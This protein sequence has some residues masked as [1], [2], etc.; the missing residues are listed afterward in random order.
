MKTVSPFLLQ[1]CHRFQ[2]LSLKDHIQPLHEKIV[3]F[4]TFLERQAPQLFAHFFQDVGGDLDVL[5]NS[6]G[7]EVGF[8]SGVFGKRND[9]VFRL[10][11]RV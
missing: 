8:R 1:F 3:H 4:R 7:R 6:M 9:F 10:F 11:R 5:L 2:P